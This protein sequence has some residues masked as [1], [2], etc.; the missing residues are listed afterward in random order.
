MP[1]KN[2]MRKYVTVYERNRQQAK[3]YGGLKRGLNRSYKK[4][5]PSP[6]SG[7]VAKF[8]KNG[9]FAP[10]MNTNLKYGDN[11]SL[12]HTL[13]SIGITTYRLNS[14]YDVD[15]T[16][17]GHQPRYYDTLCGADAGSAPYE[18]YLVKGARYTVKFV[19]TNSSGTSIGYVACR[20]RSGTSDALTTADFQA[21]Q[22]LPL[23]KWKIIQT[24]DGAGN[25]Q[26]ISGAVSIA[27]VLGVKDITDLE[28]ARMTYNANPGSTESVYLDIMYYPLDGSTSATI[29]AIPEITYFVQFSELNKVSQS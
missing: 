4:F 29:R 2:M 9:P 18:Q 20:V 19:N 11:I 8:H 26:T 3:P 23:T 7:G 21:M 17:A 10:I 22:E 14:L 25:I 6:Q 24:H 27:K 5:K 16:G 28:E 13:G 12:T 15:Q 1:P